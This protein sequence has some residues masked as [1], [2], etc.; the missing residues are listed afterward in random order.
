[1]RELRARGFACMPAEE[2]NLLTEA[3][4]MAQFYRFAAHAKTYRKAWE[5]TED[6]LFNLFLLNR[7]TNYG[8]MRRALS[9]HRKK[10][11]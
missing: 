5:M 2:I 6:K 11:K 1:M 4:Y 9:R 10:K 7:Y 3:G 8:S